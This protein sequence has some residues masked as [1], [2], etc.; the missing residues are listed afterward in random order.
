L[1]T[2]NHQKPRILLTYLS[3]ELENFFVHE[4]LPTGCEVRTIPFKDLDSVRESARWANA[5][6]VQWDGKGNS[7]HK[8]LAEFERSGIISNA[9]VYAV[10]TSSIKIEVLNDR[11]SRQLNIN[12]WFDLP[13]ESD[14]LKTELA[15]LIPDQYDNF[16]RDLANCDL[17]FGPELP[18]ENYGGRHFVEHIK[19]AWEKRRLDFENV[20]RS[21]DEIRRRHITVFH[22]NEVRVAEIRSLL[23]TVNF[24]RSNG[25]SN[26]VDCTRWLRTTGT[27]C[28]VVW[29]GE[30]T[31]NV[32]ELIR[33]YTEMR[34]FRRVPI[35][36][37]YSS[38]ASLI[39]FK[40]NAPDLFVDG[41]VFFD[42]HRKK[43][44]N[45]ILAALV[46]VPVALDTRKLLENLRVTSLDFPS[47]SAKS[48]TASEAAKACETIAG[49][50]GKKY[51]ADA[52]AALTEI[53]LG[54][55]N[56]VQCELELKYGTFDALLVDTS[57]RCSHSKEGAESAANYSITQLMSLRDL[58]FDRLVRAAFLLT[59]SGCPDSLKKF[60]CYWWNSKER[61]EASFEFYWAASRWAQ[62]KGFLALERA[63]L[64]LAIKLEPLRNEIVEAYANHLLETDHA[65]QVYQLGEFLSRSRY[66]PIKKSQMI[67]F[68]V[69]V[70]LDD[71]VGA[72]LILGQMIARS[73]NDRQLSK[74]KDKIG[75]A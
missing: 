40:K 58:N 63:F 17:E 11:I 21:K 69:L 31:H 25:F 72:S 1:A 7:G 3:S 15:L 26:L 8:I 43:F 64:G 33:M 28:L 74:L 52:E 73:P 36:V 10:T 13:K 23:T 56:Q 49:D 12:R 70:K 18:F 34:T 24:K 75:M 60:L 50:P 30:N 29:C 16:S 45:A 57:V 67:L 46:N 20:T 42:R 9:T 44:E 66:F 55:R 47:A 27:D 41:F 37:L 22:S 51:W 2:A 35:L 65:K 62:Q 39:E 71:K 53:R 19:E 48:L 14:T 61:Y 54:S 6:F 59:R 68:N 4:I 5:I 32:E 38:D